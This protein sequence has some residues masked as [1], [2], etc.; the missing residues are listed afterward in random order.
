MMQHPLAA[1]AAV[2]R[3]VP[4][5]S[6]ARFSRAATLGKDRKS[7]RDPKKA[8][9]A[10]R[11]NGGRDDESGVNVLEVHVTAGSNAQTSKMHRIVRRRQTL[12][13]LMNFVDA[14]LWQNSDRMFRRSVAA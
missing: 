8:N 13:G 9:L 12:V 11:E 1:A 4:Q 2:W 5:S 7:R 14:F 10:V 3:A 6:C